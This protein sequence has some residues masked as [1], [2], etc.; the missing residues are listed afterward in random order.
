MDNLYQ[1]VVPGG[2]GGYGSTANGAG[3]KGSGPQMTQ[4]YNHAPTN[5]AHGHGHG[6][7]HHGHHGGNGHHGGPHAPP[8]NG[9]GNSFG[10][11]AGGYGGHGG[12]GGGSGL[13]GQGGGGGGGGAANGT[14]PTAPPG[15]AGTPGAGGGT[16]VTGTETSGGYNPAPG[17]SASHPVGPF[18]PDFAG[19]AAPPAAGHSGHIVPV[20]VPIGARRRQVDANNAQAKPNMVNTL[21]TPYY[22]PPSNPASPT[23]ETR[24]LDDRE[25]SSA[26]HYSQSQEHLRVP[27]TSPSAWGSAY[28]LDGDPFA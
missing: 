6:H 1:P 20:I 22:L 15:N 18:Q 9:G 21:P 28:S 23:P 5:P 27:G 25:G 14:A 26:S 7:G 4:A 17:P 10:G 13:G 12:G 3:G 24:L 8:N 11:N 19:H 16:G 2:G